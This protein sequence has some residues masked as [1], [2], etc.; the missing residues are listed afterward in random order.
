MK[1]RSTHDKL[2]LTLDRNEALALENIL[3]ALSGP[4]V[5]TIPGWYDDI[6]DALESTGGILQH[7][8]IYKA[9]QDA[10]MPYLNLVARG[11]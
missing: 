8:T 6:A 9:I 1:A 2:H 10:G 5:E 3:G 11:Y 4:I 7:T